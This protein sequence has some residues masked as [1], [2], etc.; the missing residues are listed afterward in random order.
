MLQT[1]TNLAVAVIAD[2]IRIRR[3]QGRVVTLVFAAI[4]LPVQGVGAICVLAATACV[5]IQTIA[6][7]CVNIVQGIAVFVPLLCLG[8]VRDVVVDQ[9]LDLRGEDLRLLPVDALQTW[10]SK[11]S[12]PGCDG[13]VK[14]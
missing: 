3:A 11:A 5:H 2:P 9:L 7:F 1:S 12:G 4:V 13:A 10:E 8:P 6:V 14:S